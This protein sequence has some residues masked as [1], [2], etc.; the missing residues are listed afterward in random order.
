VRT[1]YGLY[2]IVLVVWCSLILGTHPGRATML[3]MSV[4]DLTRQADTIVVGTVTQQQSAW[5][6]RHTAIHTDVTVAVERVL[7]GKPGDTVTLRV[8]GG[9]VGRMGMHTSNDAAFQNGER[10]LV[11]LDTT[12][13]PSSVVGMQQGKFT[14][15]ADLVTQADQTV[16][17][18]EFIATVRSVIP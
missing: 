14:V 13:V 8:A 7:A 18:E 5:D 12:T 10:V 17:L 2:T 4:E 3:K 16:R 11:F 6:A 9:V 15:K 1:W